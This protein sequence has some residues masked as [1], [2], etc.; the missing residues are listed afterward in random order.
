MSN[1]TRKEAFVLYVDHQGHPAPLQECYHAT[2]SRRLSSAVDRYPASTVE[3]VDSGFCP[4]C[5]AFHDAATAAAFGYCPKAT[6]QQ[7]PLCTTA[8]SINVQ[9]ETAFYQCGLCDWTS[10]ECNLSVVVLKGDDGRYDKIELARALDDLGNLVKETRLKRQAPAQ[11]YFDT[12]SK[13]LEQHSKEEHQRHS[14]ITLTTANAS[15]TSTAN[16]G[17]EGWSVQ[18]LE[19]TLKEKK[20][21]LTASTIALR[22]PVERLSL[23]D[24]ESKTTEALCPLTDVSALALQLQSLNHST[25]PLSKADLLPLPMP[26]RV[27]TSR[28]CRAELAEGRPGILLKPKLNPMEGDSSLRSGHGQW[29]KKVSKSRHYFAA[30]KDGACRSLVLCRPSNNHLR[31][32]VSHFSALAFTFIVIGLKRCPRNSPGAPCQA[33]GS[34]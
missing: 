21:Q 28:R 17:P 3:E 19:A 5:L 4:Q 16:D 18:A 1:A 32:R 13:A 15:A 8:V 10:K 23:D 2:A 33:R 14:R 11:S 31:C 24:D 12:R 7:C 27:R 34:E 9:D 25:T 22:G 20:Q 30:V 26:L 29:W 6:C